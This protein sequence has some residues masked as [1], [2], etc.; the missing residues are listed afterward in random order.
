MTCVSVLL[1]VCLYCYCQKNHNCDLKN[2]FA[3]EAFACL[4][5]VFWLM[6]YMFENHF[7]DILGHQMVIVLIEWLFAGME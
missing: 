2:Y 6:V 4:I 1:L 5:V 3:L 7:V